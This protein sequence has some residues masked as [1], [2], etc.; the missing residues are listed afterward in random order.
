MIGKIKFYSNNKGFGF[1]LGQDKNE[2]FF[3]ISSI[4][5]SDVELIE[6]DVSV[7]FDPFLETKGLV[8][9]NIVIEE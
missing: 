7:T 4:K 3:H 9:K 1:I 8:A 5:S 2:Y 6:E